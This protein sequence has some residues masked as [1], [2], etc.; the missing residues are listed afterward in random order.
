[1]EDTYP[2]IIPSLKIMVND[3]TVKT[4]TAQLEVQMP[5]VVSDIVNHRLESPPPPSGDG[6][7]VQPLGDL[8]AVSVLLSTQYHDI[9]K[10]QEEFRALQE[11][12]RASRDEVDAL[13][14]KVEALEGTM[15]TGTANYANYAKNANYANYWYNAWAH[16]A[17]SSRPTTSPTTSP[18]TIQRPTPIHA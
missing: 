12:L 13:K 8:R 17:G 16:V 9:L 1:M 5:T 4:V 2:N 11:E 14:K 7:D 10:M 6:G 18:T 15:K 3:W